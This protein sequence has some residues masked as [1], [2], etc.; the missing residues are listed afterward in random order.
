[1]YVVMRPPGPPPTIP[2]FGTFISDSQ[3][4]WKKEHGARF[5]GFTLG[6]LQFDDGSR[7]KSQF[8]EAMPKR[9]ELM[10]QERYNFSPHLGVSIEKHRIA[11]HP[12][13]R[14]IST[15]PEK[16]KL[17]DPNAH[18]SSIHDEP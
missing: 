14:R 6:V 9:F 8:A 16:L 10:A 7:A 18:G 2:I 4:A 1:M 3:R 11:G 12:V 5:G 13:A 17:C 15:I